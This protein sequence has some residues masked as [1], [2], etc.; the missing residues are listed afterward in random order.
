MTFRLG[1]AGSAAVA[2]VPAGL[3][4]GVRLS[5]H[6]GLGVIA[7]AVPPERVRQILAETG[8][9]SERERN[10]P[11]QVVVYYAIALALH[12]G[13]RTPAALRRLLAGLRRARA[14]G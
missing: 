12:M 2:G 11:A 4:S 10:L 8:K 7:R 5:D 3:P 13:S 14:A 1:D 9:A 6:I